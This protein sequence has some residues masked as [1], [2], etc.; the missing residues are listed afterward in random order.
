MS[1][2]KT[3]Q[4]KSSVSRRDVLVGASALGAAMAAAGTARDALAGAASETAGPPQFELKDFRQ[5]AFVVKDIEASAKRFAALL[6]TKVPKAV[7]TDPVDKAHTVYR[8]R[9]TPARAK[10]AFFNFGSIAIELIEPIGGPSTWKD[11]LDKEGEGIHHVAFRV[12]DMGAALAALNQKGFE[13]IQT[14]DFTGGCYAYVDTTPAIHTVVEL[15][16]FS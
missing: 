2:E 16:Q 4:S 8:G 10:L 13:T 12:P 15:L 9:P 14:G 3:G 1:D 11:V 6:G 5:I 7:T